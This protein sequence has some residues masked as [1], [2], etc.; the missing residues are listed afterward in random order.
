MF[1]FK[2]T[3]PTSIRCNIDTINQKLDL[4]TE[5]DQRKKDEFAL[6]KNK[7]WVCIFAFSAPENA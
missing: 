5:D 2:M 6:E 1:S 7:R 3:F 4:K